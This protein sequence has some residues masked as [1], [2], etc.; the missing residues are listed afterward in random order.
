MNIK[1]LFEDKNILAIDKPAGVMVHPDGKND[2]KKET[3]SD[4]VVSNYP[5]VKNVGEPILIEKEGRKMEK[6]LRPGIVHRLDKETSGVLLIAKNK[7]TFLFL[8]EQFQNHKIK[9]TYRAFVYGSVSDPKASLLTGKRGIINVP[10][11]RS[12]KD[13]QTYT[14]GRGAREPV[15]NAVTEYI[16]L[17]KFTDTDIEEEKKKVEHQYT[18]IEAYPKTGRTHQIR[19]HMRYINHP[20]VSDPLYRGLKEKAL[21]MNRLALHSTSIT[22]TMPNGELKTV[23]SPLPADFKKVIKKYN[24]G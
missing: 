17:N 12:Q 23:E 18:Y 1:I 2:N 5:S 21:G 9:K 11:G 15:R 8:K 24:I 22:F 14:A 16:I 19:V 13:I 7:K 6:I 4:W 10:I 3:I 20:I